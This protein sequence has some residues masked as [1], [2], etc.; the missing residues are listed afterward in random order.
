MTALLPSRTPN[1]PFTLVSARLHT[2]T[3]THGNFRLEGLYP[4][5]FFVVVLPHNPPFD[6]GGQPNRN[7]YANTFYPSALSQAA[8]LVRV[9]TGVTAVGN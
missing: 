3:D 2:T 6:K 8:K 9:N 4:A 1:R 7:G 5:D